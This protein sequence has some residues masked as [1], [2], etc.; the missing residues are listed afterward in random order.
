[1]KSQ[2]Y[3]VF[4]F[5]LWIT[6][7]VVSSA[8]ADP[9]PES[10]QTF[11]RT[12]RA[13]ALTKNPSSLLKYVRFPFEVRGNLD[14]SGKK[15][16]S[17]KGFVSSYAL[18]LSTDPGMSPEPTTMEALIK[19]TVKVPKTACDE[20]GTGFRIGTW[21]FNLTSEGWRFVGAFVED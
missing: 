16:I 6:L 12:F 9:C 13:K 8:A 11:W 10:T 1:L 21:T 4:F 20:A 15:E 19:K 18:L 17:E 7:C 5:A 14:S 3:I 2:L